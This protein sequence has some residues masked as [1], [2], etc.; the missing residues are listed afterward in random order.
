MNR[1]LNSSN[2]I[3]LSPWVF[4]SFALGFSWLVWFSM[5]FTGVEAETLL[6][7][8]L[9]L[10]G[11]LL[12]PSLTGIILAHVTCGKEGRRDYWRRVID[13]KRINVKW[14]FVILFF[15]PVL[16][17][18]SWLVDILFGGS[19]GTWGDAAQE[20]AANPVSIILFILFTLF[21]GPL[22][23]FGWRGYGLDRLQE[24]WNALTS[25]LILGAMWS[26]WH[27][28]LFF[29][30]GT[31]QNSLGVGTPAFWQFLLGIIPLAFIFTW[32]FNNTHRSTLAAILFH[33]MI[34]FTGDMFALSERGELIS[35]I[36]WAVVAVLVTVIWGAKSFTH[37]GEL[38]SQ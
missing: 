19:G 27:L 14:W 20:I 21:L 34:N 6:G 25:S 18:I 13:V 3:W 10:L 29:F 1:N 22:E 35:T 17:V 8:I 11:L 32:I 28:P 2:S 5:F 23:E 36:L 16:Y 9:G 38:P 30:E 4:F 26:I 31:Y 7:R 15:V 24:R 12:G 33:F 37:S